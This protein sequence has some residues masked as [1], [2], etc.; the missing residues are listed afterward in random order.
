M[1]IENYDRIDGPYS[2]NSDAK[3]LSIGIAGK[4]LTLDPVPHTGSWAQ[5]EPERFEQVS[6][7]HWSA[8]G[9]PAP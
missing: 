7:R 3:G 4:Y 8:Y 1:A 9:S 6:R 2:G 5:R